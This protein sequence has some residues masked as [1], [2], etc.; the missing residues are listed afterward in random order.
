MLLTCHQR[1]DTGQGFSIALCYANPDPPAPG[2]RGP[3]P[4]QHSSTTKKSK[5]INHVNKGP[6]KLQT[7]GPPTRHDPTA[8]EGEQTGPNSHDSDLGRLFVQ[9]IAEDEASSDEQPSAEDQEQL[10]QEEEGDD[11]NPSESEQEDT[12]LQ[13]DPNDPLSVLVDERW[14]GARLEKIKDDIR[15]RLSKPSFDLPPGSPT[16]RSPSP[17]T[18]YLAVDHHLLDGISEVRLSLS[19]AIYLAHLTGRTLIMPPYLYFKTCSSHLLCRNMLPEV[20]LSDQEKRWQVPFEDLYDVEHLAKFIPVI[21]TEAFVQSKLDAESKELDWIQYRALKKLGKL[22]PTAGR[23]PAIEWLESKGFSFNPPFQKELFERLNQKSI[24]S[25]DIHKYLYED[26]TTKGVTVESLNASCVMT[27]CGYYG[28][29]EKP[30]R[31]INDTEIYWFNLGDSKTP[32]L[33]GIREDFALVHH[34]IVHLTGNPNR[35][36]HQP[37]AFR[38][39]NH[40]DL[41]EDITMRWLRYAKPIY[42]AADYLLAKLIQRTEGKSYLS[43]HYRRGKDFL[44]KPVPANGHMRMDLDSTDPKTSI[45]A[46]HEALHR[47]HTLR[48]FERC[49]VLAP[50][51]SPMAGTLASRRSSGNK[52]GGSNNGNDDTDLLEFPWG[53]DTGTRIDQIAFDSDPTALHRLFS[54]SP[55]AISGSSVDEQSPEAIED[56]IAAKAWAAAI[57]YGR[58]QICSSSCRARYFYMAT[59]ERD[60][61]T[62]V[63]FKDHGAIVLADLLDKEFV[64]R[65]RRWI[66]FMDWQGYLDQLLAAQGAY[67]MGSPYSTFSGAVMTQRLN[68]WGGKERARSSNRFLYRYWG[69]ALP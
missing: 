6:A 18:Y 29:T 15:V 31:S 16:S 60:P 61:T 50:N 65:Y 25:L 52:K 28:H 66:G 26:Q 42:R 62:M 44:G 54:S 12:P 58:P 13:I 45:L 33:R 37:F 40:R 14:P 8:E 43:V 46:I 68:C 55:S 63:L 17:K 24:F 36:S 67:F 9:H 53:S 35:F 10:T 19:T 49:K 22:K 38:T 57:S 27:E 48:E 2:A 3:H 5:K 23:G 11:T 30:G 59:D 51:Y 1:P 39:L 34:E 4:Q 56:A 47:E 7:R 64:A 20:T 69:C 32:T 41:Y 21:T